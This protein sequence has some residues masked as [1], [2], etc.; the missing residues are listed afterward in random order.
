MKKWIKIALWSIAAIG[1]VELLIYAQKALQN[2][3]LD[4]PNVEIS[5]DG[6]NSLLTEDEL[7]TRLQRNNLI[8]VNQKVKELKPENI[9]RFIRKMEE[10]K[11]VKVYTSFGGN[12]SI[13]IELRSPIAHIFNPS[14]ENY[15]IDSDGYKINNSIDHSARVL[16]VTTDNPLEFNEKDISTIIN[17]DSL[18]TIRKIDDVYRISNYV[19]NDPLMR[20]LIGQIHLKN[21]GDF[22]LIP[23]IGDQQIIFGTAYTTEDIEKK[24]EKLKIFYKEAVPFEGWNKYSEISLKYDKQIV[25]KK[26][27]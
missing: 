9:E 5:V 15:F 10:V 17:N 18:K 26:K 11:D 27:E 1:V 14:G 22:V 19:C 4:K 6:E 24:I 12:W 23:I 13:A 8:F 16:I 21:N 2:L 7:Q 20:S 3:P 25:C